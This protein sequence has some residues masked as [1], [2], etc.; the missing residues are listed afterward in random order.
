M[1]YALA[2]AFVSSSLTV[3]FH[4]HTHICYFYIFFYFSFIFL[5]IHICIYTSIF[6]LFLCV[7]KETAR[8]NDNGLI[9]NVKSFVIDSLFL[10][11]FSSPSW[12]SSYSSALCLLLSDFF[13]SQFS[14]LT[15]LF[16]RYYYCEEMR[17]RFDSDYPIDLSTDRAHVEEFDWYLLISC[18]D[19]VTVYSVL[20]SFQAFIDR[21]DLNS[22]NFKIVNS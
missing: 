6:C 2:S 16:L 20:E 18:I 4:T 19:F 10:F 21:F 9:T 1:L 11:L 14:G 7:R 17:W 13:D 5:H 22:L 8:H 3:F 12:D 15:R